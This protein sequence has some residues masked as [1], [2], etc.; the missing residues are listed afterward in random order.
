MTPNPKISIITC[1]NNSAQHL[2]A[3]L[4]SVRQQTHRNIE[5]VFIDNQSSDQTLE[6]IANYRRNNPEFNVILISESDQGIYDALN[7][8]L[9]LA[10]GDLVGI[11]HSDDVFADTQALARVAASFQKD[12]DLGFY[13]S[14]MAIY[15]EH[16]EKQF[17]ILGAAP[18]RQSWRE[19]LYSSTY[20]A[21][22]TYYY[23]QKTIQQVGK[24][25]LQ[26]QLAADIDWLMR[27]EKLNLKYYFDEQPLLKFRSVGSSAKR[28]FL[29][30][31][32]EYVIRRKHEGASFGLWLLYGYHFLRRGIRTILAVFRLNFLINFFRQLIFKL[33]KT[34]A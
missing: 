21:H 30:L 10:T 34:K 25:D 27:L 17:A 32:E 2:P 13:C 28:Y 3:T 19:R 7:K 31:Q 9:A 4:D 29:A 23:P 14:R 20:Y 16:L 18:H 15:D 12:H 33:A 22:P 1:T 11:L 24:Y 8:G 6:L 26:Y 5:H